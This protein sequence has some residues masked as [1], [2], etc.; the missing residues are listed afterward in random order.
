MYAPGC[1]ILKTVARPPSRHSLGKRSLTTLGPNK[2]AS[3]YLRE[4]AVEKKAHVRS[5]YCSIARVLLDKFL[6]TI[7]GDGNGD[8]D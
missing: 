6:L 8:G 4:L 2:V 5:I 1:C 7:D 3:A